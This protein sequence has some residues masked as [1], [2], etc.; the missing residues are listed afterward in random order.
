MAPLARCRWARARPDLH[1]PPC[2]S[3]LSVPAHLADVMDL[4]AVSIQAASCD[5]L[6]L[7][8]FAGTRGGHD[9]DFGDSLPEVAA[10]SPPTNRGQALRLQP[11]SGQDFRVP[12]PRMDADKTPLPFGLLTQSDASHGPPDRFVVAQLCLRER[13][14]ERV[15]RRFRPRQ[16]VGRAAAVRPG[17]GPWLVRTAHAAKAQGGGVRRPAVVARPL[18]WRLLSTHSVTGRSMASSCCRACCPTLTWM[19]IRNCT[20]G[21]N[22]TTSLAQEQIPPR[23]PI[24]QGRLWQTRWF[25]LTRTREIEIPY[26]G[27]T[28]ELMVVLED[29]NSHFR[30]ILGQSW[31]VLFVDAL[32]EPC[33]WR[34]S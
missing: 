26:D 21:F 27:P 13:D 17:R 3:Q 33:C 25:V 34:T 7:L 6:L 2:V 23:Q 28:T 11:V 4:A 1:E 19:C 15:V 29:M 12:A 16:G 14:G 18:L 20:R 32:F 22:R 5:G 8:D 10:L 9:H 24:A 31:R 30:E